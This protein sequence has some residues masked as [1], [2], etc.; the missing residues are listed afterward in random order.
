MFAAF[1]N[2]PRLVDG[3]LAG[4]RVKHE[5]HFLRSARELPVNDAVDFGKLCHQVLFVVQATRCVADDHIR[6]ACLCRGDGVK[7]TLR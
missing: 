6:T 5:K 3:V 1:W 7:D 4:G 2:S